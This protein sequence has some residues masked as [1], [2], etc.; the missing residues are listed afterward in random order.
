[1]GEGPLQFDRFSPF[2]PLRCIRLSLLNHPA[3][4]RVLERCWKTSQAQ[5]ELEVP[6][7][8]QGSGG[9]GVPA[10]EAGGS[11]PGRPFPPV[12]GPHVS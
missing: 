12:E 10:R 7:H 3:G 4:G 11:C 6:V 2:N 9:G 5:E 1:M 8:G